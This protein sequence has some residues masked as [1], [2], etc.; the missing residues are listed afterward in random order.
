MLTKIP[1]YQ[2]MRSEVAK[3]IK[4]VASNGP[5][6]ILEAGCGRRW[7]YSLEDIEYT[8]TGV[9]LDPD[10]LEF[11]KSQ[12]LD[13]AILGDLRT[14]DIAERSFDVI[15]NFFVLEHVDGVKG[16]LDNFVRWLKPN[17][18]IVLAFP[19]RDSVFGLFTRI[20]PHWFHIAF[21]RYVHGNKNAGQPGFAPY[22]TYYDKILSR[23]YFLDYVQ[24]ANLT[25]L[26]ERSFGKESK[27]VTAFM[28]CVQF[29][30]VGAFT[31]EHLSMLYI[32]RK[33]EQSLPDES[34]NAT[35]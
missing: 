12:D 34:M 30:T 13:V 25:V 35:E 28:K 6:Q 20:T 26:E 11:R 15:H 9:D 27:L 4:S 21:K 10:A 18:I 31:A 8:L 3:R 24:N 14:V 16:V 2:A 5:I 32:L 29:V 23:P 1:S 7:P 22:K 33:D 17:G 19:N